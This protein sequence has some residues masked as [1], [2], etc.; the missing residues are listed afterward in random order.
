MTDGLRL[1]QV[2]FFPLL[3]RCA[4]TPCWHHSFPSQVRMTIRFTSPLVEEMRLRLAEYNSYSLNQG[5]R[6]QG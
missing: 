1:L 3:L 5:A 4:S 2:S 6:N